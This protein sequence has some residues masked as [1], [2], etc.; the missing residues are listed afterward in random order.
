MG[1][2]D[3]QG[4]HT[5][6]WF[7]SSGSSNP[8]DQV[9]SVS[10]DSTDELVGVKGDNN[11]RNRS[12]TPASSSTSV[13]LSTKNLKDGLTILNNRVEG[14]LSFKSDDKCIGGSGETVTVVVEAL[15]WAGDST[16]FQTES[17]SAV[18]KSGQASSSSNDGETDPVT[19]VF[20]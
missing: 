13:S 12:F 16:P 6:T 3:F 19:Y 18:S 17:G 15:I 4:I 10:I 14:V 7:P 1:C 2:Y 20:A 5:T 8:L 11:T 9:A